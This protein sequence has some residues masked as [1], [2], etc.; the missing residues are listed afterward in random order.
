M[1]GL[2]VMRTQEHI[3]KPDPPQEAARQTR[4]LAALALILVIL[5]AGLFLVQVLR[6]GG[7]IDDCLMAGRR[8]CDKLV[9]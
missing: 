9:R 7:Q 3:P 6:R 2:T 8:D 5:V 4:S 1:I